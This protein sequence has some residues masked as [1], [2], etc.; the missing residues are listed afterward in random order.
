MSYQGR[1]HIK[2]FKQRQRKAS[3]KHILQWKSTL[4]FNFLRFHY[5]LYESTDT[6]CTGLNC[7]QSF[8]TNTMDFP[9]NPLTALVH[10]TPHDLCLTS[11]N[12]LFP[13]PASISTTFPATILLFLQS[14]LDH[15]QTASS[16]GKPSLNSLDKASR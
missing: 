10:L 15:S 11:I 4:L 12:S 13:S 7:D 8:P 9:Q 2:M 5:I 6:L 3:P 14:E 1:Q 16:I